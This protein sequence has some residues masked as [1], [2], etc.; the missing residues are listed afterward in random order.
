MRRGLKNKSSIILIVVIGI[1][2]VFSYLF[3]QMV[4]RAEDEY[5]ITQIKFENINTNIAKLNA[6]SNQLSTTYETLVITTIDLKRFNNYW[7]KSILL[8][9]DYDGVNPNLKD[10]EIINSFNDETTYLNDLVKSRS[11]DHMRGIFIEINKQ[12]TRL[13]NI[14]G[15][16]LKFFP[17]YK[18]GEFYNGPDI[19]YSK[20][21]NE[22]INFFYE[23]NFDTYSDVVYDRKKQTEAIKNFKIKNWIDINKY[24]SLLLNK[25]DE[26]SLIPLE[27]T[28]L[29]DDLKIKNEELRYKLTDDLMSISSK[30]NYFI[31]SSIISQI[32]SLLFLL[33]L[34]RNLIDRRI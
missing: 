14:Y 21:Y 32:A 26:L 27:D 30:K 22:N 23:K 16:N 4:I 33:I 12:I 11:I 7:L 15:W 1:F 9:T 20:I 25:L 6:I 13:Q 18:D 24:S 3:D 17:Q 34:F 8:I 2:T 28:T 5:R 31:L 10:Q 19:D 29:I